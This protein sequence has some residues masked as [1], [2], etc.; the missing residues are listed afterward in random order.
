M[1][2][3]F[4]IDGTRCTTLEAFFDEV[5]RVLIPGARWGRNLNA[6]NDILRGGF[7]TPDGGFILIWRN[8]AQA[9]A[10]LSYAETARCFRKQLDRC[11]PSSHAAL[12]HDLTLAE[13]RQ[14]PTLFD[15]I[16]EIIHTHTAEGPEAEDGV[17]LV[18]E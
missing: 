4:V 17:V 9:R 5:E 11:D 2:P 10:S 13:S 1:K 18:L 12:Q 7:G 16:V 14:G 3:T 8:S 6:F 15:D